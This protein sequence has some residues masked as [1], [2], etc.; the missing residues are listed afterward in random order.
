MKKYHN[1]KNI[2]FQDDIMILDIDGKTMNF[3]LKDVSPILA[4]ATR[5]QREFFKLSPSGY[6]IY[7]PLLD[8]DISI[9]ALLTATETKKQH[10]DANAANF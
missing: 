4:R 2:T 10:T 9:D 5:Q 3:Q 6:G 1:I 8:E 7:W